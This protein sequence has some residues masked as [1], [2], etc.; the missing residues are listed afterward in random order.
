MIPM[1]F[2]PAWVAQLVEHEPEEPAVGSSSLP[3]GMVEVPWS[4]LRSCIPAFLP[5]SCPYGVPW[6]RGVVSSVG[7]A[8]RL[9]R[10]GRQFKSVTT[11]DEGGRE[12]SAKAFLKSNQC[13]VRGGRR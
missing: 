9:H 6:G 11:H 2:H 5:S 7:R 13:F 12:V 3:S 4:R 1:D 8:P 10:V